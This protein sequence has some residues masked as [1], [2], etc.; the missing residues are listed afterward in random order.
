MKALIQV[1]KNSSVYVEDKKISSIDKGYCIF[2]GFTHTDTKD[3]VNKMIKKII[4]L[5]IFKDEHGKTNLS[6]KNVNGK[7]LLVSQFTLY[8]NCIK[9][10]RPS[11]IDSMNPKD[12]ENLY[13]YMIETIK[14]EYNVE[15]FTGS[16]GAN[17][18][19]DIKNEGP[20]TIILDSDILKYE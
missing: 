6:I 19:V 8:A 15:T 16:F 1:V 13:E 14:K 5:R 3:I 7:I 17:M 4:N 18:L 20:F 10:N 12:A 11:F 2:V 9:G